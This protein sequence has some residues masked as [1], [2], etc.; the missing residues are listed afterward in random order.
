M[1]SKRLHQASFMQLQDVESSQSCKRFVRFSRLGMARNSLPVLSNCAT[2]VES[3]I[4]YIYPHAYTYMCV[5]FVNSS[6]KCF[7]FVKIG[8]LMVLSLTVEG[9]MFK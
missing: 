9:L 6:A 8:K 4:R 5:V 1:S 3:T 2:T 7:I